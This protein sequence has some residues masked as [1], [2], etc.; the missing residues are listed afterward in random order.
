MD[1]VEQLKCEQQLGSQKRCK[2]LTCNLWQLFH[3]LLANAG[4]EK[5]AKITFGLIHNFMSNY[6]C[7][8]CRVHFLRN[9]QGWEQKKDVSLFLHEIHNQ[10]NK[11]TYQPQW[12]PGKLDSKDTCMKD[13]DLEVCLKK[14]SPLPRCQEK[15]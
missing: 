10:V 5:K 13:D 11:E 9:S 14:F 8:K 4:N 7:N 3:T 1:A 2:T 12:V 15:F 6:F